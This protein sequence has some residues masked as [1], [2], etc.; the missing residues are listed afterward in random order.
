MSDQHVFI[1]GKGKSDPYAILTVGAQQWKTKHIDNDV[2]PRWDY[3]CEV[4]NL[5]LPGGK[6]LGL[7][8]DSE[9]SSLFNSN[10]VYYTH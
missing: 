7:S 2:N 4:C 5:Y 9:I 6:L 8:T 10:R 1:P 3:W